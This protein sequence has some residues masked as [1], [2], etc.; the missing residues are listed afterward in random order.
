MMKD[1][2]AIYKSIKDCIDEK[3]IRNNCDR[4]F[5]VKII[6]I[7]F[8]SLASTTT[9]KMIWRW[10]GNRGWV[11]WLTRGPR[12]EK[13]RSRHLRYKQDFLPV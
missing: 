12:G 10:R 7:F 8:A 9:I 5:E 4:V 3:Y 1:S 2:I 11:V 6:L 13:L